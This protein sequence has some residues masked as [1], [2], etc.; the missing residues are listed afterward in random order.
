MRDESEQHC[1]PT[2]ARP[3]TLL[4]VLTPPIPRPSTPPNDH[5]HGGNYATATCAPATSDVRSKWSGFGPHWK[6]VRRATCGGHES[7]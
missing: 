4:R 2:A 6:P 5:P 3:V 1:C 7:I